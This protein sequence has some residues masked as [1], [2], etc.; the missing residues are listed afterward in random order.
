MDW[1]GAVSER[2]NNWSHI[3]FDVGPTLMR[4]LHEHAVDVHDGIV[5]ADRSAIARTGHG[6]AMAQGYHHAILPLC[7]PRD[8]RTEIAWGLADFRHRF[9]REAE[10]FWL[11]ETAVDTPTLCDLADAGVR[12][13]VLAPR[14]AHDLHGGD[15]TEAYRVDL[16]GD[17]SIA[18][19]FYDGE[20]AQGVAFDGWLHDGEDLAR[21]LGSKSGGL[22][23]LAT[24]G[25]SY[26]H[27]HR[28]GEMALASAI[29]TLEQHGVPLTTYGAWLA[30][31]PPA[32]RAVICERS[33]WSCSHGV[34]RWS[35]NCGCAMDPANAG[36]HGWRKAVRQ[37]LNALRDR[38]DS[39]SIPELATG[40]EDPWALRDRYIELLLDP[41]GGELDPHLRKVLE[42]QRHRLMMFT[43]CGWF[44]DDPAGIETTQILRYAVRATELTVECGGPD[45]LP[46]LERDLDGLLAGVK[47]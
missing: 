24:D 47:V 43:S 36:K 19:F 41:S 6:P 7:S 27:H 39:W 8:R 45:L 12:Y 13:V 42:V 33:S 17:R 1:N 18:A 37:A 10:G 5:E 28:H 9:G 26:G 38:I 35:E 25:E 40:G 3:S 30:E 32:R 2:V 16:P 44:F 23:H 4:W 22:I 31:H 29:R 15:T 46:E 20:S 14:Q 11:P 21:R 34:G